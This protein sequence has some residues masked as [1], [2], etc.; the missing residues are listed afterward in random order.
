MSFVWDQKCE[1]SFQRF[2]SS[3]IQ[4]PILKLCDSKS[5][6]HLFVDASNHVVGCVLKRKD[7]KD[8]SH[9]VAYH[10]RNLKG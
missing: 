8:V 7:E 3:L 9:T 1:H 6:Y 10:S 2:K 5:I 4:E